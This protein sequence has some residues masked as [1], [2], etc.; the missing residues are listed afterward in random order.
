MIK[1]D[2]FLDCENKMLPTNIVVVQ[3]LAPKHA[4]QPLHRALAL[5]ELL[6]LGFYFSTNYCDTSIIDYHS[7]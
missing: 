7:Q 2:S 4:G 1:L 6:L 5:H 3:H